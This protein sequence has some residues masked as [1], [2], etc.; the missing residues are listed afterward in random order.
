MKE[1]FLQGGGGDK[2]KNNPLFL[3]IFTPRITFFAIC[4]NVL[5]DPHSAKTG[6]VVGFC[7]RRAWIYYIGFLRFLRNGSMRRLGGGVSLRSLVRLFPAMVFPP[8]LLEYFKNFPFPIRISSFVLLTY[9]KVIFP[10]C[11]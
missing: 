7:D 3:I 5:P 8:T 10:L 1:L 6:G 2:T 4:M 11:K 9:L